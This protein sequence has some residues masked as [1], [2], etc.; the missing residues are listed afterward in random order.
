K[1]PFAAPRQR[2]EDRIPRGDGYEA[3]ARRAR[4]DREVALHGHLEAIQ[5]GFQHL[6]L[7]RIGEGPQPP[8]LAPQA[9]AQRDLPARARVPDPLRL[10][11]PRHQEAPAAVL[12]DVDRRRVEAAAL[13]PPPRRLRNPAAPGRVDAPQENP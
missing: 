3:L 12:E 8:R 13:P 1:C 4:G 7:L 6:R 5:V 11:A 10:S 9:L 2:L